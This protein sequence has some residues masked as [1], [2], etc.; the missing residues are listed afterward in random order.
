MR[1]YTTIGEFLAWTQ[2]KERKCSWTLRN[3]EELHHTRYEDGDP[4]PS[5][6]EGVNATSCFFVSDEQVRKELPERKPSEWDAY[7]R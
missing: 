4:R 1:K 7:G 3:L 6:W 5:G 2:M